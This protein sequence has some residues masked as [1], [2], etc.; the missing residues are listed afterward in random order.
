MISLEGLENLK[1]LEKLNLYFNSINS[2][3]EIDRL[4][5]NIRLVEIDLRLNP[6]AKQDADY[7]L[8][9]INIL[10]SLQVCDDREIKDGEKQMALTYYNHKN[11][12][13]FER[14]PDYELYSKNEDHPQVTS[15]RVKSISNIV[16]RSAGTCVCLR[17]IKVNYIYLY[18]FLIYRNKKEFK[19]H[20][21]I[22]TKKLFKIF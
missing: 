9:L 3:K 14:K 19:N 15:S 5:N 1:Y 16:K 13:K 12:S 18:L 8:Y 11:L 7:R 20:L 17:F 2:L 10:P 6:I 22:T 21:Q 4:A